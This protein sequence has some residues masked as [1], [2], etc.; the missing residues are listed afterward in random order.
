MGGV[1][2][3]GRVSAVSLLGGGNANACACAFVH[4]VSPIGA[5]EATKHLGFEDEVVIEYI[6]SQLEDARVRACPTHTPPAPPQMSVPTLLQ[7]LLCLVPDAS[8]RIRGRL[9][10]RFI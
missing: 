4:D 8:T 5:E 1:C 2:V 3:F 7:V 6:F 10:V 9:F